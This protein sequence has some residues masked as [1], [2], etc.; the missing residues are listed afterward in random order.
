VE[1]HSSTGLKLTGNLFFNDMTQMLEQIVTPGYGANGQFINIAHY[2]ALG[3]ELE[4]EQRWDSG[5]LL[6]ASYT[7]SRVTDESKSGMWAYASPQNLFKLH[8]AEPLFNNFAKL[9][10]ENIFIGESRTPQD[11]IAQAYNQLNLNLSSDRILPG[12]DV[13]IGAYNL[14]DTHYQMVGGTGPADIA[15]KV[16]PMNGRAFRLKLQVTF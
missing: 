10:I 2:H 11:S 12:L 5:R 8:Y 4:A 1:W 16:I 14:F 9:G 7:Y 15:Q 3:G 6:K 13:S